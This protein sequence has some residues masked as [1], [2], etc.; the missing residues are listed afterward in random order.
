VVSGTV[1]AGTAVLAALPVK[2]FGVAKAR[3]GP[4]VDAAARSRLGMAIAAHTG[5]AARD[6]GAEV[7]VV[8]SDR[9]VR[10]WASRC[11][12]GVI[13]EPAGPGSGLD[14]AAA[15]A[16]AEADRRGLGWCIVHADLP[17][18]TA[19]DLAAVLAVARSGPVLVPSYDG[20]TNLIAATGRSFP[21]AYGPGSFHRHLAAV[22]TASV[23]VRPRLALDL[24]TPRDLEVALALA[25]DGWLAR[26]ILGH[27]RAGRA[28]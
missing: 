6:A 17:L 19:A 16:A 7:A 12:F 8:T 24:D 20:G 13:G 18:V 22:P 4:A 5:R 23:L 27:S 10:R 9:Q 25:T 11:G 3:L 14:R 2:P 1:S 21:F 28:F 15:A 26:L